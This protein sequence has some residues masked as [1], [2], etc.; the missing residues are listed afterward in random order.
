MGGLSPSLLRELAPCVLT[1]YNVLTKSKWSANGEKE[2]QRDKREEV[3]LF[4]ES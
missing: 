1:K 3:F 2:E 4:S